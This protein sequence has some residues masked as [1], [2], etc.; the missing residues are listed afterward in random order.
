M[1][2]SGVFSPG[3]P[4]TGRGVSDATMPG[5]CAAPPA[6]PIITWRPRS[7]AVFAYSNMRSGVR[8]AETILHSCGTPSSCSIS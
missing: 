5:R 6:L 2:S 1:P 8:W 7:L 4:K 3:T